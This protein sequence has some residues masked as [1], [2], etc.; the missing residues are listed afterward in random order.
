MMGA[1]RSLF[2]RADPA[3][4]VARSG[5][6]AAL[7]LVHASAFQNGWSENVFERLLADR[8][9]ICHVARSNGGTGA[10]CAFTISRMV[11]DE[12][13]ILM[14]AVAPGE[15]GRG[16][17]GRLLS[18][19]LGRLAARGVKNVF[20]EVD[21]GNRSAIRLYSRAGFE[22]VGRRAGYYAKT[23]GQAAALVLRRSLD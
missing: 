16:L 4:L 17:A 19:H 13:E 12:A 18:R 1:I 20:L 11:E 9:V 8:N 2:R 7:A 14:V 22:Q 15:Q 5:D 23:D 10:T 6:A 21:E 3:I